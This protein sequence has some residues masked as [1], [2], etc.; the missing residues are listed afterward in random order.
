MKDAKV[1]L[2]VVI[3]V[4]KAN[5]KDGEIAQYVRAKVFKI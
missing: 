1:I 3:L 2:V 4:K 5:K